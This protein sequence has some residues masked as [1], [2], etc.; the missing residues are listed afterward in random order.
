VYE[1]IDYFIFGLESA[2]FGSLTNSTPQAFCL[3][4]VFVGNNRNALTCISVAFGEAALGR[5]SITEGRLG[6]VRRR[7]FQGHVIIV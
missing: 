5:R 6:E 1:N 4:W 2:I 7:G 3:C